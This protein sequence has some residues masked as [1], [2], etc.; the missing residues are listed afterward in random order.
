MIL[1]I[2]VEILGRKENFRIRKVFDDEKIPFPGS[3]FTILG[4]PQRTIN[5]AESEIHKTTRKVF[6]AKVFAE[7]FVFHIGNESVTIYLLDNLCMNS[8]RKPSSLLKDYLDS[9]WTQIPE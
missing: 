8:T 2:V 9:G 1:A 4:G 5:V 6:M 3:R 7:D